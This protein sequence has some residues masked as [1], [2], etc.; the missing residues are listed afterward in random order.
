MW[1]TWGLAFLLAAMVAAGLL[2]SCS[3]GGDDGGGGGGKD[4]DTADDDT[5]DDDTGCDEPVDDPIPPD[6]CSSFCSLANMT[7]AF[8]CGLCSE[9]DV[10]ECISDCMAMCLEGCICYDAFDCFTNFTDDCDGLMDC[11]DGHHF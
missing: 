3:A 5:G 11:T 8:D 9:G 1:K 6:Q 2:L 7:I 10:N 4:D